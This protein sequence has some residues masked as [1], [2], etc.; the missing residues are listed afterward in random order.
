[1]SYSAVPRGTIDLS[2]AIAPAPP[3]LETA[4]VEAMG[5]LAA[6]GSLAR[7]MRRNRFAGTEADQ[8]AAA[9]WLALRLGQ[10]PERGRIILANGTQS[11]LGLLFYQLVGAGEILL[12]EALTYPVLRPLAQR[13]GV[14]LQPVAID[15]EGLLPEA[16]EAACERHRPKA[17]F[18]NPTLHNP[19][20][21]IM[22]SER[23]QAVIELARRFDLLVIEDDVLGPL[24]AAAPLALAALGPDVVWYIQS[25]SKCVS[26]GLKV[27]YMVAPSANAAETL[28]QS[29]ASHSFW[30]PSALSADIATRLIVEKAIE[31]IAAAI[32]GRALHCQDIARRIL[33]DVPF[34]SQSGALHIWL[35]VPSPRSA[36]DFVATAAEQGLLIRPADMFAIDGSDGPPKPAAVRV[37]LTTPETDEHLELGLERLKSLL[38]S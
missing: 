10:A 29:A 5:M 14:I 13:F 36:V 18:C 16:L 7:S 15:E 30:F 11:L 6:S 37:A 20:T 27:A 9:L 12:A 28:V 3:K 2:R 23:R 26:L 8:E 32:A 21:A 24:H 19:T 33:R 4:L 35:P 38:R 1:M 25:L 34:Y 17:L 31:D 22:G